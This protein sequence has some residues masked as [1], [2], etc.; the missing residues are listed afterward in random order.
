MVA[1][2][3]FVSPHGYGHAARA[4]AVMQALFELRSDLCYEVFTTV[5][6]WFFSESLTAPFTYHEMVTDVG[7]V[8]PDALTEDVQATVGRLDELLSPVD[9]LLDQIAFRLQQLACRVVLCDISPL[10][11]AAADRI[12][13]PSVLIESFTWDWIYRAYLDGAGQAARLIVTRCNRA[14]HGGES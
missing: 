6:E 10:G 2:A 9:S 14:L 3:C 1:L 7:L 8:Q 11:L 5:P 12:G 4:C 13:L